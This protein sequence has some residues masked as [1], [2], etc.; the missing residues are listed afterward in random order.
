VCFT[1]ETNDFLMRNRV[2]DRHQI[3]KSER[4]SFVA[5]RFRTFADNNKAKARCLSTID[6]LEQTECLKKG[7][8]TIR[9]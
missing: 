9:G 5:D 1:L 8:V 3:T 2:S 7:I 6:S 4:S